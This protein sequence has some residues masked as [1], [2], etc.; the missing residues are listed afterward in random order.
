MI[1]IDESFKNRGISIDHI[2]QMRSIIKSAQQAGKQKECLL[3]G[4]SCSSFCKSHIVPEFILKNIAMNGEVYTSSILMNKNLEIEHEGVGK[5]DTF[6]I[7][8][9]AC[10][11]KYFAEYE[12]ERS[13]LKPL[14]NLIMA[15]I[16]MKNLMMQISKRNQEIPLYDIMNKTFNNR[17]KN[18]DI[19]KGN[20]E[21]DL[22]DYTHDLRISK[23][24]IDNK[25]KSGFIEIFHCFLD[26]KIPIAIQSGVAIHKFNGILY[27]NVFDDSPNISIKDLHLFAFP[28][29]DNRSVVGVF[30]HKND[31]IYDKFHKFL[32]KQDF[33]TK[34]IVINY[35]IFK[36]C[37]NFFISKRVPKDVLENKKLI[38]ISREVYEQPNLGYLDIEDITQYDYKEVDMNEIPNLLSKEYSLN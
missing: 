32:N 36:Y 22:R 28:L 25:L 6:Y 35:L 14:N 19:L 34:L 7:I 8:C 33:N 5:V 38:Q 11:K 1:D 13:L 29:S 23:K 9:N 3:C 10:D 2:K 16:A 31:R 24:I 20:Q 15:E 18:Q 30:Y 4:C 17:I 37:E 12:D 21:L 27:N 26:Y